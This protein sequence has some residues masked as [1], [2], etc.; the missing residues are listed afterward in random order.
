[1]NKFFGTVLFWSAIGLTSVVAQNKTISIYPSVQ[2]L[3][4]LNSPQAFDGFELKKS[5]WKNLVNRTA[6]GQHLTQSD[7][8]NV[9]KLKLKIKKNVEAYKL[10]DNLAQTKGA[11]DLVVED[12]TVSIEARDSIGI[13]YGLQSLRQL[14]DEHQ[15]TPVEII[16][17]PT[18]DYRGVVEGFYGT[19]WSTA[20]RISQLKFYGK[21]KANTYIYGPKDDPYH[22][23]P[24]WREPYPPKQAKNIKKLVDV[25]HKNF[26]DFVW[27]IHPGKDI[28]WNDEDRQNVL[29]KFEAMYDLGVRSFAIFFDDISGEGTDAHKQAGLMNYLTE[30]F[31]K[32]K[33]D[34]KPLILCPTEYNKGWANPK[35]DG[36]LSILGREMDPSVQIMWTGDAVIADITHETL[37][38]VQKRIQRPALIWWNFP[39][40]DYTRSHLL[41][42]P[43][44]GL[45]K[46]I[47]PTEMSGL[48]SNP[49]ENAEASK[50]AIFGVADFAWNTDDYHY[51]KAWKRS[52]K[53]MLPNSY[54]AYEVFAENNTDPGNTW[55]GYHREE[56]T[57]IAPY[58]D[59]LE[60][61]IKEGIPNTKDFKY[62]AHYFTKV[63]DAAQKIE[64][65][66][67]NPALIAEI[68]PWL[69]DF[70]YLGKQVLA[71]MANYADK[72]Q[73][74]ADFWTSI[75]DRHVPQPEIPRVSNTKVIPVTGTVALRPFLDFLKNYN[76]ATLLE[77]ITG[78]SVAS[79]TNNGLG[80][81]TTN[82][83]ALQNSGLSVGAKGEVAVKTPLEVLSIQPKASLTVALTYAMHKADFRLHYES[84]TT[85]WA[86]LAI[87]KDGKTW[88][89]I[90]VKDEKKN[91]L[92]AIEQE[93]KYLKVSN[94]TEK[95]VE[96]RLKSISLTNKADEAERNKIY[97]H[98][99]SIFSSYTL[100]PN[101]EVIEY[102]SDAK[103][104]T[105]VILT[106]SDQAEIHL[107][108]LTKKGEWKS[109]PETFVGPYIEFD[110]TEEIK[111]IKITS[112]SPVEIYEVIW[113]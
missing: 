95:P 14:I 88:K 3:T 20:D 28:K 13:F 31:V 5:D 99:K 87:S 45:E 47:K 106:N 74:A 16:D 27:A 80:K 43:S 82:I 36:Y 81:V 21:I 62:V 72:D 18:V 49:M 53:F 84:E 109:T 113:K 69:M 93:F 26:V 30:N 73:S 10:P 102:K 97:T 7:A 77:K 71:Q 107:Q 67:D 50:S 38:W 63:R 11:Y 19:P 44:Y 61:T 59:R 101:Q 78:K 22:S 112:D 60:K 108:G 65:A 105:L 58:I 9:W 4:K 76:N 48:L 34:V 57:E 52:L 35:P 66:N 83:E 64:A 54:K 2:H 15:I 1:M 39:V 33:G 100:Q 25:A 98:D 32:V 86:K 37:A 85:N 79:A 110:H 70:T 41:I 42:G 24:N 51:K 6:I 96:L 91:V 75:T 40:S 89:T 104:K 12:G 68:K 23:S 17:F 94:A 56:S 92:A 103:A 8:D 29:E 55:S 111:A 46:G 90:D